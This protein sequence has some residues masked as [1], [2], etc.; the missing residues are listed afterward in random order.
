M[1]DPGSSVIFPRTGAD[2]DVRR[3]PAIILVVPHPAVAG[4]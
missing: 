3:F 4:T 2:K 1:K